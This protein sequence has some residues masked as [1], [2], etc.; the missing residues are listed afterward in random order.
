MRGDP[1]LKRRHQQSGFYSSLSFLLF[2]SMPLRILLTGTAGIC[3]LLVYVAIFKIAAAISY[4]GLCMKAA[5]AGAVAFIKRRQ[6]ERTKYS[7]QWFL[8]HYSLHSICFFFDDHHSASPI[9][10]K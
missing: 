9:S 8:Q 5:G 4:C 6:N 10:T 1:G 2:S 7:A 3:M